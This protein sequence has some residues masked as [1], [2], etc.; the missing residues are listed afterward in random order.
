[1]L[2]EDVC[3]PEEPETEQEILRKVS[4]IYQG[5]KTMIINYD[6]ILSNWESEDWYEI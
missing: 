3:T 2:Q 5:K 6:W 1:M 4:Q